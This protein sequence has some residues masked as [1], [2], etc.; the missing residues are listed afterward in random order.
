M[1]RLC[2]SGLIRSMNLLASSL[3]LLAGLASFAGAQ[4]TLIQSASVLDGTGAPA[5]VAD[6]RIVGD[7]I[8]DVGTIAPQPGDRPV[9][10]RGLVL[11]PGFIDTHS[12]HDR[13][14]FTRRDALA[15]VSQGITTIV[16]GQDG[17]SP[18]PLREF[19]ARLDTQPAAIN[20][21]AYAGHGTIRRRVLGDDFERV[22]T[23][24]EVGRMRALL[25]EEMAAGA[26]GLSSGLE[27]DPGIYS[28]PAEV[29]ELAKVAASFGGRYISHIRSEDREFWK[30]IDEIVTIGREARL[31][32]QVSHMK[33][34]MRGLWGQ[35]DSLVR[36]LDRARAQGVDITA[37]V[38]PYTAWQSTLTVLYPKRNFGDRAETEF[39]LR[40]VSSPDDLLITNFGANPAY[41]GKTVRQ[42]AAMRKSDP[43]TTLMWLIAESEAKGTS[44]TVVG[45]GMDE[46]DIARLLKW[47]YTSISSDGELAGRHPRGYGAF[48]RVLGRAV[49][50]QKVLSLPEAV[51]RMTSL[52]A[53]NMG[54]SDRG[55]IRPGMAADLVL[56]DPATVRDNATTEAPNAPSTGIK[57]VWV[58]GTVVYADGRTTGRYPGRVARR[59]AIT[60]T[61]RAAGSLPTDSIA[62]FVRAEL[63]R[64]RV[65][66]MAVAVVKGNEVF[67]RGYGY[68]NI[69]HMV[70]VTERTIFQSGSLGKMFTSAAVMLQVEDGKLALSDPISKFFPDAPASWRNITVRHLLTHTSGIPDYTT[71]AF[72]YRKDYTEA[73]LAKLAYATTLE[74]PAGSR[75][76]YS[77]TGYALLGFIV[78][79]VAGKHYGEELAERVFKP[80]GMSTARII[81]EEE[82]VPNRAAGYRL[83]G[84]QLKNQEW[85]APDLN[86][87]A[88]G[89]LYFSLRDMLAWDAAVRKRAVLKPESWT[90][91]LTPVRLN[92]GRNYPYGF[93]WSVDQRAGQAMQSHGG[94]WQGFRTQYT[95]FLGD[96]V[97]IIVLAN[98]SHA[99]VGGVAEGIAAILNPKLAVATPSPIADREPQVTARLHRLLDTIRDGRL[100]PAEFAYVRAGFFPGTANWYAEQLKRLGKP[101]KTVLVERTELGD[102]RLYLY[103]LT[104]GEKTYYTRL[105]LAP[106]DRVS[107]FSL[108]EKRS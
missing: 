103:E 35:A 71:D 32:V 9:D 56:F 77:N 4:S 39:V 2:A 101:S 78:G 12:H 81:T 40:E 36:V 33:L 1:A 95:R 70:P 57:T 85:V 19:F 27:Y 100:T 30:A 17:G 8:T 93:G 7:R 69:E 52:S 26:L 79:K 55:V 84:G 38:Y 60:G 92:S 6:V 102:D 91:I 59:P 82:I 72:D 29:I 44:E 105:G 15:A 76:N 37:D 107:S 65:P 83:S 28:A 97:S 98:A 34:A 61:A 67:E 80:I 47:P 89:S 63:A 68:A 11:A 23:D 54:L 66:G 41:A 16:A 5:R 45:T 13:G 62:A 10:G 73:E 53:A 18:F 20:V 106:D 14:I 58:N 94:A 64:Q 22:A 3:L 46:R 50:E 42:I 87:T 31:P 75:W 74:F 88:D 21:A 25:R 48:T 104:F 90:E 99:D 24:A 108:R 51:R 96:D 86:T 49:R 43:A